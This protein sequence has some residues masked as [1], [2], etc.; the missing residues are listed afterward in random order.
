[1]YITHANE[2][3]IHHMLQKHTG[4]LFPLRLQEVLWQIG[5]TSENKCDITGT[6]F[7]SHF[8]LN[9]YKKLL[10]V[11]GEVESRTMQK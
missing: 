7:Y 6:R 5:T 4:R 11:I 1:M 9:V 8:M 10:V 3:I 2:C